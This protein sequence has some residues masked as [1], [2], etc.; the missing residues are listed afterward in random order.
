MLCDRL[1]TDLRPGRDR[2]ELPVSLGTSLHE[3]KFQVTYDRLTTMPNDIRG[4]RV[5][6]DQPAKTCDQRRIQLWVGS[7]ASEIDKFHDRFWRLKAIMKP[8][9]CKYQ[10]VTYDFAD[11]LPSNI[12]FGLFL[13][14]S[15][16]QVPQEF[17]VN[18]ALTTHNGS[19]QFSLDLPL[20]RQLFTVVPQYYA[21]KTCSYP[22][23]CTNS[24]LQTPPTIMQYSTFLNPRSC[25]FLVGAM[26]GVTGQ[27]FLYFL[28]GTPHEKA[29]L[30]FYTLQ[31][32]HQHFVVSH[33]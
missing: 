17:G 10:G 29:S 30:S 3:I 20:H 13:V 31:E 1:A 32:I 25:N 21:I 9:D 23:C 14:V 7:L 22:E 4:S 33:A 18:L 19:A 15:Q 2:L 8:V 16:S 11:Q 12:E 28:D 24:W 6:H 27:P 26:A 5:N